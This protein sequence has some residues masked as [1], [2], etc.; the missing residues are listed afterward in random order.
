MGKAP[1]NEAKRPHA[2]QKQFLDKANKNYNKWDRKVYEVIKIIKDKNAQ[3]LANLYV[4][5]TL[6][7]SKDKGGCYCASTSPVLLN[8]SLIAD[9][10]II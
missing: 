5:K 6:M 4:M 8:N 7:P 1:E 10:V 9:V 2:P 3:D